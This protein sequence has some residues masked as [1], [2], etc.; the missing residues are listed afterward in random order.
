MTSPKTHRE[1]TARRRVAYERLDLPDGWSGEV[2]ANLD[3]PSTLF[4]AASRLP[5]VAEWV[6]PLRILTTEP[7]QLPGCE[8]LKHA[9]T[10]QVLRATLAFSDSS[11]NVICKKTSPGGAA[12]RIATS[13]VGSRARRN[14]ARAISL[15]HAGVG[16]ALPLA[17]VE[18]RGTA[19]CEW[20]ISEEI[21]GTVDLD[22]VALSLLPKL[23]PKASHA[24]K[25]AM[26]PPL[27]DVFKRLAAHGLTHR[28]L[29]A[30]NFLIT[31]WDGAGGEPA[32]WIVDLDGLRR[33]RP[34][35]GDAAKHTMKG[36]TRL[37]ASLLG[38]RSITRSD[39]RRFLTRFLDDANTAPSDWKDRFRAIATEARAY[40]RSS[41]ARK[42]H[43]LDGYVGE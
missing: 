15:L 26:I 23:S 43:K 27:V 35:I 24:A 41:L 8:F 5:E 16:T 14:R 10:T 29:K 36:L 21:P 40:A 1:A 34:L 12:R 18:R 28:D 31:N 25:T 37:T 33:A 38:Y 4:A 11:L 42:G 30:S 7:E 3:F 32:V 20:L 19:A 17:I 13:V 39:Y 6:E 2:V 22:Q 9:K